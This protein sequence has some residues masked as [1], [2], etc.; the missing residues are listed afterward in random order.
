MVPTQ[1]FEQLVVVKVTVVAE[2][3]ER[4]TPVAG[5][6]RVSVGPVPSQLLA[7]VPLALMGEDLTRVV[8]LGEE[9]KF[10]GKVLSR[11]QLIVLIKGATFTFGNTNENIIQLPL[12]SSVY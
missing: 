5:V 10:Q 7:V 1:V 2:L 4:V 9:V 6:V 12:S 8:G 11:R 3:A